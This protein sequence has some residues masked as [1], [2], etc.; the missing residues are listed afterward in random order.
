MVTR[1]AGGSA[2]VGF[3]IAILLGLTANNTFA[4][5][6]WRA[7]VTMAGT[8]AVGLVLGAMLDRMAQES[9]TLRNEKK[10]KSSGH[11]PK[12]DR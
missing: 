6:V 10:E 5:T 1:I 2:L 12:V 8:F 9:Q 11:Q 3:A 7:L 4:T